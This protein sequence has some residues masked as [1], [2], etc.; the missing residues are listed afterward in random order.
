[1]ENGKTEKKREG[2]EAL[3]YKQDMRTSISSTLCTQNDF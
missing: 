1:M 3:V 2:E